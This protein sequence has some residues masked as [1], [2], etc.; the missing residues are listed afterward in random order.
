MTLDVTSNFMAALPAEATC[1]HELRRWI[2]PST[3]KAYEMAHQ[4]SDSTEP[5][6]PA[7]EHHVTMLGWESPP[8]PALFA[9]YNYC[10]APWFG[11]FVGQVI[12]NSR[13]AGIHPCGGNAIPRRLHHDGQMGQHHRARLF[14]ECA[15][16]F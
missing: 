5:S 2:L 7:D 16:G 6:C 11:D 3:G 13:R 1:G 4:R 10:I 14:V 9:T 15:L 8:P 12:A